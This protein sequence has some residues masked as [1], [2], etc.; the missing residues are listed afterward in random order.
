[1]TPRNLLLIIIVTVLT[2]VC[3]K[4]DAMTG[5]EFRS[6][7]QEEAARKLTWQM[8]WEK[9]CDQFLAGN[10]DAEIKGIAVSWMST[11]QILKE[12]HERGANLL[13]THE[14]LYILDPDPAKG[15]GPDH[16]WVRK[17]R[18]LEQAGMIVYRCHDFWDD[19]PDI[20]IHGAWA[21]WLGF[22]AK[23][24]AMQRFY[25]VHETGGVPL[26]ALARK[27]LDK[28]LAFGQNTVGIVGDATRTTHRI[29]LGTGAITDY[30]AMAAMGADVLLLTDDGTRLWETAQ[31]ASDAGVGLL[32]VNHATAEE[33]GMR[34]L[35]SYLADLVKPTPVFHLP[36]GCL[37]QS[38]SR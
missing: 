33:P 7:L 23:P 32:I 15:I 8:D 9:T 13:V 26:K 12:A 11:E 35:A 24:V 22:D 31:W 21:K 34:T 25:E 16:P 38:V 18:W 2:A 30:R 28:T 5:R 1:M 36:V 17:K 3:Q 10:P 6:R 29:A 4:G 14:P 20:G 27:V 19:F 37:Y